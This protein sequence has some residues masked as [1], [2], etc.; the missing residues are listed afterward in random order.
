[1]PEIRTSSEKEAVRTLA[2]AN[3]IILIHA[4]MHMPDQDEFFRYNSDK[5]RAKT[6]IPFSTFVYG[7]DYE[8]E[9]HNDSA[10]QGYYMK[11]YGRKFP[12]L[13]AYPDGDFCIRIADNNDLSIKSK[14]ICQK[15]PSDTE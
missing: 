7:G 2:K 3:D 5:A 4:G 12:A 10:L 11:K 15:N 8:R 9:Y 6:D 14:L 1:M 13:F